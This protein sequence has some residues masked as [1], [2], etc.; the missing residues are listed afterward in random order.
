ML[1]K[2]SNKIFRFK[3]K[4]N[5]ENL[6]EWVE[7]IKIHIANSEGRKNNL[8][9]LAKIKKFWK[10]INKKINNLSFFSILI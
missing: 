10:V 5:K 2:E 6:S 3:A 8:T 9:D 1:P 4:E 7:N